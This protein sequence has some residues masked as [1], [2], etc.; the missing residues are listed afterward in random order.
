MQELQ[1]AAFWAEISACDHFVQLYESD[2]VFMD[3]LIGYVAGGLRAGQGVI[4][5]ATPDHRQELDERLRL[6]GLDPT[7]AKERDQFIA[8][9]AQEMLAKFAPDGWPDQE[10]FT[11]VIADLLRRA[12]RNGRKVRAF[13]EMVALLWAKGHCGGTVRLEHLWHELCARDS[14]S[15]FCAYPKIGFTEHPKESLARVCALHS[16]VLAV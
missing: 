13:G 5:I 9:D 6:M 12:G 15:L 8:M 2:D 16:K 7:S 14:F 11:E 1:T 10:L 3:T 4:V